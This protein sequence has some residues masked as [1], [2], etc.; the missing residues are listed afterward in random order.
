MPIWAEEINAK[1]GLL[2]R[3]VKLIYYDDQFNPATVPGLY[4]KLLD[5]DRVDLV[6]SGYGTNIVVPAL[7]VVMMHQR[8]FCGC[9]RWRDFAASGRPGHRTAIPAPRQI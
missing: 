3:P 6:I 2:G 1:G 5:V 9:E 8:T 4:T 7:S